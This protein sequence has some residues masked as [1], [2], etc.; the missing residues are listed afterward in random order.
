VQPTTAAIAART[1]MS[2]FSLF[3]PGTCL[4]NVFFIPL[5]KPVP[6]FSVPLMSAENRRGRER[7]RK[8]KVGRRR[9]AGE[10]YKGEL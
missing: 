9:E 1:S 5:F 6:P 2:W 7:E 4:H 3:L 8:K 10:E